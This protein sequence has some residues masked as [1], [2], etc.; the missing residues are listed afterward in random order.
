MKRF[1][2]LYLFKKQYHHILCET[3]SEADTELRKLFT[4]KKK[5]PLGIYDD[6]TELFYWEPVR[7]QRFDRL[8][9]QEQGKVG[10]EMIAIAQNLR[11]RDDHWVPSETQL[12]TD[13][14]QRPLFLIHD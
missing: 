2:V 3:H 12:P 5:I 6:K 1:S 11:S 14:L 7:Q 10:N 9:V 8:T 4:K 13:I